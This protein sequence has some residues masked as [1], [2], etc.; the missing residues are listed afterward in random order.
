V[1]LTPKV[2]LLFMARQSEE[3]VNTEALR[4]CVPSNTVRPPEEDER[5]I[6]GDGVDAPEELWV[7]DGDTD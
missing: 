1:K 7:C 6:V 3:P 2:T 5:V 4:D